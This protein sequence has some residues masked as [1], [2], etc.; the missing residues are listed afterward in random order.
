[1]RRVHT[2][3][4]AGSVDKSA[5]TRLNRVFQ[6]AN[7]EPAFGLRKG[8]APDEGTM[9][10]DFA[11][12]STYQGVW[13]APA[14]CV[15]LP[16]IPSKQAYAAKVA[17]QSSIMMASKTQKFPISKLGQKRLTL[18]NTLSQFLA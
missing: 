4:A 18:V 17:F 16:A 2:A 15:G 9:L 13:T 6:S 1:M 3:V 8:F 10:V 5:G 12:G 7:G 14:Y 11:D